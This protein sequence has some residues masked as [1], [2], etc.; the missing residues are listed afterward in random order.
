M[1]NLDQKQSL[2]ASTGQAIHATCLVVGT[3]GILIRGYSGS[4]K[5]ALALE[6]IEFA[7]SKNTFAAIVADDRVYVEARNGRLVA[8]CPDSVQGL[9]ELRGRGAISVPSLNKAVLSIVLDI[10]PMENIDR[11]PD[12]SEFMSE[13][14]SVKLFRQPVPKEDTLSAL[15]LANALIFTNPVHN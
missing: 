14:C 3:K 13:I 6:L 2:Q 8:R 4:G 9:I 7:Q 5:S 1:R 12:Q 15:R 10:V 11:I